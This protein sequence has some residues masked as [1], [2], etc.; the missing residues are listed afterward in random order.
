MT[1]LWGRRV[2]RDT[3]ERT[4]AAVRAG[5]SAALVLRGEAGV[6]KTALLR[7]GIEAASGLRVARAA[8]AESEMELPFAALH[9]VCAPMIDKLER[10]PEPQR[11][12]LRTA[13]G[14]RTG[15]APDRFLVGLA[16]LSLLSE[17]AADAPLLV[18]VDDAHWLDRE[19]AQALAF[20]ARRLFAESVG[21]V[22]ATREQAE[23][24]RGLPELVVEGLD[25]ADA[26]ELLE[27]VMRGPL[28][29]RVRDRIVAETR[30]N[31]LALLELARGR[32]AA[33]LA[34]GFG[35]PE[36]GEL[37]GR[38]EESFARRL[39][40]L[41]E[42]TRTLLL[43]AA[44]EPL[45]DPM[46]VW[47]AAV[48]LGIDFDAA[49]PATAAGLAEFGAGVRFEHPL[50][51]SA[52]YGAAT[53]EER[54]RA[55]AALAEATDP[56]VDP[57]RRAWHRAHAAAEPD[58]PVAEELERSA[59][60]AAARGGV[61]AAAAFRERAAALTPDPMRRARRSLDAARAKHRA[62]A[63]DAAL[64]LVETAEARPLDALDHA[65]AELLRAQIAFALDRSGDAPALLLEA[66]GRLEPLDAR[67]ARETYLD[68]L[69]ATLF[70]GGDLHDVAAAARAAP[71]ADEPPRA[72][73]LLL[74]GMSLAVTE[75]YA[76]AAP[77]LRRAVTAFR[78]TAVSREERIRWLW[79]ASRAAV[80]LWDDEAWDALSALHIE[81]VREAGALSELPVALSTRIAVAV[82]LG[83]LSGAA[84]LADEQ[85]AV[86]EAMGSH[87]VSYG[88]LLIS[89]WQ[90]DE[91]TFTELATPAARTAVT[92]W[93]R[94]VLF[95]GL[96]RFEEALAAAGPEDAVM[97]EQRFSTW[98]L[99]ELVEAAARSGQVERAARALERFTSVALAS[100]SE[101]ARGML[102]RSRALVS[103]DEAFYREA[104]EALGRTRMAAQRAR[105]HL[106]Y[107][108]WLR[109]ESRRADA[110]EQLRTAFAML[111]EMGIEGFAARAER[112]LLGAGETAPRRAPRSGGELTAQEAQIARLAR[113]GLSNPEIG[114][115]LFISPRTVEY[116]LHKVFT[117]LGI[118]SRNE[119]ASVGVPPANVNVG[120]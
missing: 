88:A 20:V 103:G 15:V 47:R 48:R 32:T 16:A 58:E 81:M 6:G 12:A 76:A 82:N 97:E 74:D 17:T 23:E 1:A 86:S 30:G 43:V 83:D 42:A 41:P 4:L 95:N 65:R 109:G 71:A 89:A 80:S 72:A 35:L 18:C 56:E 62:G 120:R 34:G 31:P 59:G 105:V 14:E 22:F 28:D 19:S 25:G 112:E 2:E 110:R 36:G 39:E 45:G 57:D 38:I 107:G 52:A 113:D 5:Q 49:L 115:R 119:L 96:G 117:K 118:R 92:G 60:R 98:V 29:A 85:R 53:E 21:L 55:H 101:W 75:G 44:A 108:E 10:I 94:T 91:R 73:D 78:G 54:R 79:L 11:E 66:A 99:P 68:A 64:A 61:A 51:R 8:G 63:F 102:A 104:V 93:W 114:A 3:L 111:S 90:G 50:V 77:V 37:S 7:F 67:L 24:L 13:F 27:S 9:Q 26:R 33:E 106:L 84:S 100:G 70:A 69:S 40:A 87:L 116:H 46:L